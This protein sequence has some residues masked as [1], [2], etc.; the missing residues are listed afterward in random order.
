ME[1]VNAFES[2]YEKP[3]PFL[4]NKWNIPFIRPRKMEYSIFRTVG[5]W[6]IPFLI[7]K[8]NPAWENGMQRHAFHF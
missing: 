8:W 1:I 4:T 7:N 2:I 3:D 6:N 5:K